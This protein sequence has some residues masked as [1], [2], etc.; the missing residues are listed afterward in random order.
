MLK[1]K[2]IL[3]PVYKIGLQRG[4]VKLVA[5]D[6]KWAECF[7]NE[8][9][10]LSRILA[11]K[12]LDIRHIGSTS[13]AGIPAKPILDIMAAVKT[14]SDVEV[15]TQDLNKIGYEDKGDDIRYDPLPASPHANVK[16]S[17]EAGSGF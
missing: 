2:T 1:V 4:T 7:R 17:L 6:P 11:E 14:L 16:F 12:V 8:K 13:I 3:S 10:L 9:E 15:F 5:H